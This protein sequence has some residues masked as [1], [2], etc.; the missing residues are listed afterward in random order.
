MT[1]RQLLKF[2]IHKLSW[3]WYLG[4][5]ELGRDSNNICSIQ[6]KNSDDKFGIN[7]TAFELNKEGCLN[8][9]ISQREIWSRL[10]SPSCRSPGFKKFKSQIGQRGCEFH[11]KPEFHQQ[12][13]RRLNTKRK[14]NYS[15]LD[16]P[17]IRDPSLFLQR[18]IC[19][20]EFAPDWPAKTLSTLLQTLSTEPLRMW[21]V[22]CRL[23]T[24]QLK[25]RVIRLQL[26]FLQKKNNNSYNNFSFERNRPEVFSQVHSHSI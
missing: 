8:V 24:S 22:R 23:P 2:S 13:S 3:D 26:P 10:H 1:D 15:H 4:F 16:L 11:S 21:N 17:T 14:W 9:L 12:L 19:I 25:P 5:S 7:I 18:T 6:G 20:L